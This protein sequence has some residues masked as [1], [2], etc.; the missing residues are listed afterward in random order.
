MAEVGRRAG[1]KIWALRAVGA[2]LLLIIG[3][4]GGVWMA[5]KHFRPVLDE[6]QDQV[7]ACIAARDNLVGLVQGQGKAMPPTRRAPSL[8]RLRAW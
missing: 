3:I 1:V 2:V 4:G 8:L 5:I 7:V 6:E